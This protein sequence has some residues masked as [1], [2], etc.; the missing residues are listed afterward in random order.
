[1]SAMNANK[2]MVQLTEL[3]QQL[4]GSV[5]DVILFGSRARNDARPDSDWDLLILVNKDRLAPEDFSHY[6][7]PFMLLGFDNDAMVNP[8]LYTEKD[9]EKRSFTPLYKSIKEEGIRLCH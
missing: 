8:L 2:L 5:S 3:A 4:S 7:Y 1:M 9:W 6:A